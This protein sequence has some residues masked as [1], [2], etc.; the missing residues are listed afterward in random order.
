[1]N[2]IMKR[3]EE[4]GQ[5]LLILT[6][7]I[8]ALV[9]LMALAIDGGM[10]YADRRYD[11]NAA[12]ASAF[13]GAGTLAMYLENRQI[14]HTNFD[15]DE[16]DV[17]YGMIEAKLSA[18]NRAASNNFKIELDVENQHGVEVYCH[19]S[20]GP[21]EPR[22]LDIFT[23]VSSEL[24][25]SFAHLFYNGPVRNTVEATARVDLGGDAG[26]GYALANLSTNCDEAL[27]FRGGGSS[28]G[29]GGG[30]SIKLEETGAH[31]NGCIAR[32][33]S[34]D[35]LADGPVT[36]AAPQIGNTSGYISRGSSAGQIVPTPTQYN[37]IIPSPNFDAILN[38]CGPY[39]GS[40]NSTGALDPGTWDTIDISGNPNVTLKPGLYCI[41][42]YFF[43]RNGTL[44]GNGV[45]IVMKTGTFNINGG[46]VT[47]TA[48]SNP[49]V[50]YHNLL[51][52]A[53]TSNTSTHTFLGNADGSY[54]GSILAPTGKVIMGG[55]SGSEGFKVQIVAN[56][57][58]VKGDG[59]LNMKYDDSTVWRMPSLV[60]LVK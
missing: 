30:V 47:L 45:T 40:F 26:Y 14:Y 24:Q 12:D 5:I 35:V 20:G 16:P 57:V 49:D 27:E 28:S 39:R 1:M 7:G 32:R 21:F 51:F 52:Y 55:T 48:T 34:F 44:T 53:V 37:H 56:E 36:H 11:Q 15:C 42:N 10:I 59:V 8:V 60:S 58:N 46:T 13:A 6:V 41:N 33:G 4:S 9:G 31:S 3:K 22:Y 2:K 25:T 43:M 54:Q 50:D 19:D 17:A 29:G 18:K 23:M 38:Q